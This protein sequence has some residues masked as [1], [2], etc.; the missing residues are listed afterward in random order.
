MS[1]K[2]ELFA[3][4]LEKGVIRRARV[5]GVLLPREDDIELALEC[6]AAVQQIPLPLTV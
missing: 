4:F 2:W 1:A 3:D 6:C 5:Y